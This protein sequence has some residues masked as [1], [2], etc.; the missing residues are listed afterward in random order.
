MQVNHS[1]RMSE[2]PLTP[3]II[4]EP[5]GKIVCA[6]CD[7][8]AG[9]GECCSH[10]A[11][12]LWA[13]EAGVRIRDSMTVTQKEAYWVMPQS[14]KD[15]PYSPVNNIDFIGKKRSTTVFQ[16]LEYQCGDPSASSKSNS[17]TPKSSKSPT[18]KSSKSPIPAFKEATKEE[19]DAF[20]ASLSTSGTKPAIL[21]LVEPYSASYV[22]K[23]LDDN[24]PLCLSEL[25]KPEYV[26]KNYVELLKVC[27]SCDISVSQSQVE[28]AEFNTKSQ[29]MSRLWFSMRAGRITASRFKAA[30]H[31]NT[32]SP[33]ISLVMSVCYPEL[34]RFKAAAASWGC[35]HEKHAREKYLDMSAKNH[36]YF[37]VEESGLFISTQHPF[38][39][40]SPD[41]LVTC[42]CCGDGICEI[43]VCMLIVLL[44]LLFHAMW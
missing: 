35:E 30:S 12:L 29:S 4:A 38:I 19:T 11:S 16:A 26:T 15:V 33:S 36:E 32:T 24:L 27:D 40:A 31:T 43:K 6:H 14:I 20:F 44:A 37:E 1:Q 28:A 7:C 34:S 42:D 17:P 39:G 3:W 2:R 22:P 41:G 18:P 13:I 25:F 5:C 23:S 10:V 9:L 21:S 8:K